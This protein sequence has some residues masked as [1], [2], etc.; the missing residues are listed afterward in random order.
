MATASLTSTSTVLDAGTAAAVWIRNTGTT[1]VTVTNGP[2]RSL[3]RPGSDL[4]I[5]PVG[6]VAAFVQALD[7]SSGAITYD[8][9]TASTA[10]PGQITT[11]DIAPGTIIDGGTP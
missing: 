1:R 9:S 5:V 11:A 6:A 2:E 4:D 8:V 7:G 3:I 10:A